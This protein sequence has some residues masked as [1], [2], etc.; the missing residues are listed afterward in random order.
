MAL[1]A[2]SIL[3][4]L[5]LPQRSQDTL[6]HLIKVHIYLE[7]IILLNLQLTFITRSCACGQTAT[8]FP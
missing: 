8:T 4:L 1:L 2:D 7:K 3:P 6:D 5:S